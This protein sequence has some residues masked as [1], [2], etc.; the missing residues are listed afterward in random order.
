VNPSPLRWLRVVFLGVSGL[1]LLG[2]FALACVFVYLAPALPTARNAQAVPMTVYSSTGDVIS[3]I[4]E[5]RRIQITYDQIPELVRD[6]VLAAEDDRFFKHH[7]FDWMGITR[8]LLSNVASA[9]ATGQGGSTITQQAARNM[10]L[11]LEQTSRRKASE[12]FVTFRMERALSKEEILA[13]YL[14][15]A[16]FGYRSYGIAAAAQTYYGKRLDQ[17]TVGEAATLVGLLP[18]PSSYNPISSP[19]SATVRRGYVLGRMLKL[20]YIDEATA[21]AAAKERIETREY[22]PLVD[23]EGQYVAEMARQ[24]V[25]K[26]LG[27]QAVN[28]GIKVFTTIDGRLQTAATYAARKGLI[29]YDRRRGYRGRLD[30]VQVPSGATAG[31]LDQLLGK[32]SS[33]GP[34][35]PAVVTKVSEKSAEVHIR[36]GGSAKIDWDGLKW[37]GKALKN[38]EKGALPGKAA[39]VVTV[40]D[41]VHVVTNKQGAAQLAQVP[42]AQTAFVAVNPLDGAIVSLVGG[43][44]FHRNNFNRVTQALRQ[45]ASG[46]KP[47]I[48]SAALENGF[49]PATGVLNLNIVE[50]CNDEDCWHPQNSG[51]GYGGVIRVREA[52]VRSINLI[53]RRILHDVGIDAAIDHAGKFGFRKDSLPRNETLALGTQVARPLE[54]VTAYAVFANGG[55]KVEPYFITRIEDA[56]GKVL[57]EAKPKFACAD[58]GAAPVAD[59][60]GPAADATEVATVDTS[61]EPVVSPTP[62]KIMSDLALLAAPPPLPRIRDVDAPPELRE[63][64]RMQSGAAHLPADRLAPRVIS[65]Q[66]AW[67][68]SDMMHDVTVRG[69]AQRAAREL[70]RN[71]LAGKTGTNEERDSWFNGFTRNIVATVWVGFDDEKP[72][73]RGEEGSRTALPIWIDF[74]REALDQVPESRLERPGGLVDLRVSTTTGLLADQSDPSAVY[75][76][77]MVDH[78]PESPEGGAASPGAGGARRNAEPLF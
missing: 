72:L 5:E 64:A 45:P 8:A 1:L 59:A 13:T 11:T 51:G 60:E 37:A 47:F 35:L 39:E 19:K 71:D 77:F 53:S 14:N 12:V 46:F 70:K 23:V 57:Y 29:E 33:V 58:C 15:V 44:D 7:G 31:Q 61:E 26:L 10:F 6:A 32:F 55:Y 67:L 66:N 3:Q 76:T 69:T 20:G 24:E 30:K 54:M 21:K 2:V 78:L 43:F 16:Y 4:G 34:L 74:M 68:M 41:V 40:G 18:A 42:E 48:Y 17:L 63:I 73:G 52:L 62:G 38:G 50:N 75:E 56:N 36:G 49:T 25:V 22:P 65:A 28:Q 9:D 27:P